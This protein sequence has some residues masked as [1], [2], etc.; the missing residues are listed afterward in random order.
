VKP[1]IIG[2]Y[3]K[4]RDICGSRA[5]ASALYRTRACAIAKL[6][7]VHCSSD[8]VQSRAVLIR[9]PLR[10]IGSHIITRQEIPNACGLSLVEHFGET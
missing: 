8:L 9:D 7:V 6:G 1:R 10:G 5:V 3:N 4:N 2:T